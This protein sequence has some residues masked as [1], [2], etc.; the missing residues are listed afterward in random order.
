MDQNPHSWMIPVDH[1][2]IAVSEEQREKNRRQ[3]W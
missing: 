3:F 2:E 1:Q